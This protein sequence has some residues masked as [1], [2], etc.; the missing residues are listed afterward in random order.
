MF[1]FTIVRFKRKLRTF[2]KKPDATTQ[3]SIDDTVDCA[4][5]SMDLSVGKAK[6]SCSDDE[7]LKAV[8]SALST[9]SNTETK[10]SPQVKKKNQMSIY[11]SHLFSDFGFH[12]KLL[13]SKIVPKKPSTT[14]A[15]ALRYP[16]NQTTF[17]FTNP[18]FLCCPKHI[19]IS[20]NYFVFSSS[21]LNWPNGNYN[22]RHVSMLNAVISF[23]LR[24]CYKQT[25]NRLRHHVLCGR[26]ALPIWMRPS[27]I[28]P[29]HITCE[30]TQ[31]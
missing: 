23:G 6:S 29:L 27:L 8:T 22:C 26:C 3:K 5:I 18:V 17:T 9:A 1:N 2:E 13:R 11:I 30:R 15:Y 20:C 7:S 21:T 28:E 10:T 19:L 12:S 14:Q 25:E 4:D 16:T 24:M 31:R